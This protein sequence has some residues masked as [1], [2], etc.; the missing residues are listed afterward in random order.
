LSFS[1]AFL[2]SD[3]NYFVWPSD[4]L[5]TTL[6]ETMVQDQGSNQGALLVSFVEA[7]GRPAEGML[8]GYDPLDDRYGTAWL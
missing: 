3:W 7:S 4:S 5:L 2:I 1:N 8:I 6:L